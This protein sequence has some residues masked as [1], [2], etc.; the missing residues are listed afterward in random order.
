MEL[1]LSFQQKI[2]KSVIKGTMGNT[3]TEN[4]YCV[5]PFNSKLNSNQRLPIISDT[6]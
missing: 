6:Y 2:I 1:A 5:I 4:S 3:R